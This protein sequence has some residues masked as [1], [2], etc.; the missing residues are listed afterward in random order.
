MRQATAVPP[1]ATTPGE[2]RRPPDPAMGAGRRAV[3]RAGAALPL[4]SILGGA[5]AASMPGAEALVLVLSDL[6]SSLE[7]QPGLLATVDAILADNPGVPLLIAINGDV[8]ERGQAIALRSGGEADYAFVAALR[9]RAP[10][11]LNLGNHEGALADLADVVARFR[12]MGVTV[13]SN[14]VDR[15]T[16]Q[17]FAS[18]TARLDFAGGLAVAAVGTPDLGTY[19]QPV[20]ETIEV[21]N[22][23]QWA[24]ERL[25]TVLASAPTH[26]VLSHA[27][28]PHDKTLLPLLPQGTLLVGGHDHVRFQHAEGRTLYLHTGWWGAHATLLGLTREGG[29]ARWT[30]RILPIDLEL[31]GDPGHAALIA[32]VT[33]RHLT[34]ADQKPVATLAR[35]LSPEA[36]AEAAMAI[37]RR[38][39]GVDLAAIVNT[40]FGSGLRAGPVSQLA[41]DAF[42]RFDGTMWVADD[43]PRDLLERIRSGA[44]PPEDQ[45]FASRTGEYLVAAGEAPPGPTGRLAVNGWVRLNAMRYL[46]VPAIGVAGATSGLRFTEVADRRIKAMVAA[47]LA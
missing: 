42:L 8:F 17:G 34:E 15:R 35:A 18:P 41:L 9:R 44:N 30:Q 4:A 29:Q 46:G 33:A 32:D 28:V 27:G 36:A 31:P 25:P 3:M 16:G 13:L 20:R 19:R 6:H 23:L 2:F 11:L 22:P 40:T 5:R 26:L 12:S 14:I 38:D 45:P 47:G 39:L 7:R 43:V 24:T 10:V 21:P 1:S 37:L